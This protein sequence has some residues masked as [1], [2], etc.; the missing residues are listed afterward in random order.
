MK[1]SNAKITLTLI[2]CAALI[3]VSHAGDVSSIHSCTK[4]LPEGL[5]L[6]MILETEID[7][8]ETQE[9]LVWNITMH[10]EKNEE[11]P[12]AEDDRRDKEIEPFIECMMPLLK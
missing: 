5:K 2:L 9:E 12:D 3:K 7:R 8:N 1:I 11:L 4:L 10:D 6:R